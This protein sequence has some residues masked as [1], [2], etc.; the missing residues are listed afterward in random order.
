[1]KSQFTGILFFLLQLSLSAQFGEAFT[2]DYPQRLRIIDSIY[3][4][5]LLE[6]QSYSAIH[7]NLGELK[8]LANLKKDDISLLMYSVLEQRTKLYEDSSSIDQKVATFLKVVHEVDIN[9]HRLIEAHALLYL[10]QILKEKDEVERHS[11]I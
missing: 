4:S 5:F 9:G 7:S 8:E 3:T 11:V 6:K 2:V 10:A 1:M